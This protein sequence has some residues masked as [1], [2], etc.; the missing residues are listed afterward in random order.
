[1]PQNRLGPVTS[2][3]RDG[4]MPQHIEQINLKQECRDSFPYIVATLAASLVYLVYENGI[5]DAVFGLVGLD[6]P[7]AQKS[8]MF[9]A[10]QI[11]L[12]ATIGIASVVA[13]SRFEVMPWRTSAIG[14]M[15]WSGVAILATRVLQAYFNTPIDLL[16]AILLPLCRWSS[17]WM[18]R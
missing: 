8:P 13:G 16:P 12:L 17:G 4:R 15:I 11:A 10:N 2:S 14:L 6:A 3:E 7:K 18:I 5:L 1:M 9:W